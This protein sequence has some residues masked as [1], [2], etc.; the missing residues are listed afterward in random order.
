METL[1]RNNEILPFARLFDQIMTSVRN[2]QDSNHSTRIGN[3][4]AGREVTMLYFAYGANMDEETLRERGVDFRFI[5]VGRVRDKRLV[6]H[7]PGEDGTGKADLM[8]DRSSHAHGVIYDVPE[9]SLAGLDVYEG[10]ERG[11]YRRGEVL[12]QTNRGELPCAVY[13]AAKFRNGLKPSDDYLGRLIRGAQAHGLP[14][15]YQAYLKSYKTMM[16]TP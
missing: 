2:K 11:R 15:H 10:I 8:D 5:C 12:V 13:H 7:V 14:D 3:D 4:P 9:V 16:S 6:F 1:C